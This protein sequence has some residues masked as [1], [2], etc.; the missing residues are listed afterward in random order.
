MCVVTFRLGLECAMRTDP[1]VEIDRCE[2]RRTH[3]PQK[4]TNFIPSI[5]LDS[6]ESK[7]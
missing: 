5:D 6:Q 3:R 1:E 4:S 7:N 2:I